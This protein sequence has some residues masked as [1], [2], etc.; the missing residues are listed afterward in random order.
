MRPRRAG[1]PVAGKEVD[2]RRMRWQHPYAAAA[3]AEDCDGE[4]LMAGNCIRGRGGG[5]RAA[6]SPPPHLASDSE[7]NRKKK[8][9]PAARIPPLHESQT[10]SYKRGIS[11][12][13]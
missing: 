3:A 10:R 6:L 13:S 1:L 11:V 8:I 12:N 5:E 7:G 9:F 2:A 4:Q